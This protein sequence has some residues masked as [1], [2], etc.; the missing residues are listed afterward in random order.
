MS[1]VQRSTRLV[2][3]L[4]DAAKKLDKARGLGT[5]G[6]LLDFLPRRY[7]DANTSGRL[8]E[9][10]VGETAVLVATV[11]SAQTRTMR[12][13]RGKML[14]A[15]IQDAEGTTARLVFFRAYGHESRLVP[16]VRALFRGKLDAYRGGWQLSH[17]DYTLVDS[18]EDTVYRGGL[19]PLYLHVAGV[20]DMQIT[21]SMRVVLEQLG[22]SD[23]PVPAEVRARRG[24]VD[25]RTAYELL[26]LPRTMGDVGRGKRRLRYDEAL[27]VQTALAQSRHRYDAEEA[28]PR[29]AREGGLLA[30]F[31]ERLPFELTAGQRQVSDEI[32]A[33]MAKD[34]PMHRLLQGEVG[35]GKTIVAL[36]AMLAAID[37]G[38]QAALLAPTEVLAQQH[39][40]SI[41]AML[42]DL[43]EAGMLGA[44]EHATG[45]AL[46]TGSMTKRE[47]EQVLLDIAT[48]PVGIVV[49]T[50]ALI[51]DTVMFAD[52][53]LV[54][55][56]EQHRFGVE[57][58]DALRSKAVRPPHVLV[59]TA[60]PIPRTVA[61][62]VFGDMDTSALTELPR[63]RQPI[64]SHVVPAS[65][66]AWL[67]RAWG[68]LAEEVGRGHQGYVVCPRIG[69]PDDASLEVTS[70]EDPPDAESYAD[71]DEGEETPRELHGV[72]QMLQR[73]RSEP[74]LAGVRLEML[75]GRMPPDE[76]D[77]V[78][79]AF[80]AGEVDVL[81]STTVI[82][83]GVDVPNATAM[84]IMD[85]DRFGISQLHQ[86]RGRVGRGDA[87]GLCLLVTESDN[88][89]T[90]SRLESVAAT[91]DGFALADL[92]LELRREGDVL[93]ASQSGRRSGLRLLRLGHAKDVELIEQAR[94]DAADLVSHDPDLISH[95]AL[96]ELVRSRLDDEQTAFL[97]RG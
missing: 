70:E 52:L 16:G 9:F 93:G 80:S 86:L 57:Q 55:V 89:E 56:D 35:S 38:A 15:V 61:M 67:E 41:R 29:T 85:A 78:M 72:H 20:T 17:P 7:I 5:V 37:S 18:D 13:K 53:G 91:T 81:V 39:A 95:P 96:G 32:A 34:R 84:V 2:K 66:P 94:E 65:R 58:R 76:K 4:G 51:Q 3:V 75:H 30:A 10:T 24:L 22:S 50:H 23:D 47:R 44:A 83:V 11:V 68:R 19:V 71:G 6:D 21:Q 74:A 14:E 62:T 69:D 25:Q 77:A 12:Q 31:D 97:E 82:E 60:T 42:G 43:G 45:V 88:P 46:L 90:L 48:G 59:M 49:G 1:G 28:V 33:D 8:S 73:L 64:A 87:G 26:H 79:R 36:R 27:V 92:D 54:V 63:G 40:R